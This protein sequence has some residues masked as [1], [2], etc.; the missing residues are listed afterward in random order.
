MNSFQYKADI[1]FRSPLIQCPQDEV[2]MIDWPRD[3]P[4]KQRGKLLSGENTE[5]EKTPNLE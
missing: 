2:Q 3:K 1:H 4:A 5:G